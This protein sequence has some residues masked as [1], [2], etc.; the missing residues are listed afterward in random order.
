ML[1]SNMLRFFLPT[2]NHLKELGFEYL[3][4][5]DLIEIKGVPDR[6]AAVTIEEGTVSLVIA[7]MLISSRSIDRPSGVSAEQRFY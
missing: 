4:P 6:V 7:P 2:S 3:L 1:Q 5:L